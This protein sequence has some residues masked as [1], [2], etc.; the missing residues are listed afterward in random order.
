MAHPSAHTF[1][2]LDR[3]PWSLAPSY[4]I[5]PVCDLPH[6]GRRRET[7]RTANSSGKLDLTLTCPEHPDLSFLGLDSSFHSTRP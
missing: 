7:R 1:P 3:K 2:S 4:P 6:S 5:T